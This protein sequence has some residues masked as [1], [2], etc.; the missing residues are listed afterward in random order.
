M[1][2]AENGKT[3]TLHY[4]GTLEDGTVFDT[5]YEREEPMVVTLGEG[6][7]IA[8]FENNLQGMNEGE[9]KTFTI[10]ATE[11][12][13]DRDPAAYATLNKEMFP[14]DFE[15]AEGALVPL[16]GP[17]GQQAVGRVSTSDE[18]TVTVDVNHPLAGADLTFE[19]EVLSVATDEEQGGK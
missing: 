13:G 2:I 1:T 4:K 3:V 19:V 11:A 14:E 6:T 15:Y 10:D 16:T 17:G 5:S 7:L 8:Q 9:T 18:T 12:Y